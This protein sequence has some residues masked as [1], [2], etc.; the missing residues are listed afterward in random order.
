MAVGRPCP[1]PCP[2][3]R[4]QAATASRD[5]KPRPQAATASR[6]R[7]PLGSRPYAG[8]I[9]ADRGSRERHVQKWALMRLLG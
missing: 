4:P 8:V 2:R 5:R 7:K 1:Y 3:P 9:V 6:D